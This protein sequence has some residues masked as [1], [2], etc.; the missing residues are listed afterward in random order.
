M[1]KSL[2]P[3]C[4]TSILR[5][6]DAVDSERLP[7]PHLQLSDPLRDILSDANLERAALRPYG[8]DA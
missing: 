4:V 2:D 7:R 8:I 5:D 3:K 6:E 1:Q